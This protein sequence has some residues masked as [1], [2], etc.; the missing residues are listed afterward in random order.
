MDHNCDFKNAITKSFLLFRKY[1]KSDDT[2]AV[3]EASFGG[4]LSPGRKKRNGADNSFV[5]R[6]G[7]LY[8]EMI[9]FP[10]K[11][12]MQSLLENTEEKLSN[13]KEG[14]DKGFLTRVG[15]M[16]KSWPYREM[17]GRKKYMMTRVGRSG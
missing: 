2:E 14:S 15:K 11:S 8:D 12:D 6:L 16:D 13:K 3:N 4:S 5:E 10:K 1:V 9:F 17:S 7:F